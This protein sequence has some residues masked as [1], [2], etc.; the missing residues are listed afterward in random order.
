MPRPG[1]LYSLSQK[2]FI[3]LAANPAMMEKKQPLNG[4]DR[5]E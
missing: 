2:V 3:D 5:A 1:K 4:R